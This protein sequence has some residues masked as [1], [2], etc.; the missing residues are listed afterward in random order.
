MCVCVCVRVR[1]CVSVHHFETSDGDLRYESGGDRVCTTDIAKRLAST[2][3]GDEEEQKQSHLIIHSLSSRP[4]LVHYITARVCIKERP[5]PHTHTQNALHAP[6]PTFSGRENM[7][8]ATPYEALTR[9]QLVR[10]PLTAKDAV[11]PPPC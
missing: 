11:M 10:T 4:R 7:R 6:A 1:V 9:G 8:V 3:C 2:D 5:Q